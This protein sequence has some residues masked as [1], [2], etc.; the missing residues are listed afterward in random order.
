MVG[1]AV[2]AALVVVVP[3]NCPIVDVAGATAVVA[4]VAVVPLD[5]ELGAVAVVG[6]VVTGV[7]VP[8]GAVGAGGAPL[9][10]SGV[11]VLVGPALGVPPLAATGGV[12][13]LVGS[14]VPLPVVIGPAGDVLGAAV[15]GLVVSGL[16]PPPV[17]PAEPGGAEA[18]PL[19]DP[20]LAV[21]GLVKLLVGLVVS[22]LEPVPTALDGAEA[23]PLG[24]PELAVVGVRPPVAGSSV[25][26]V[27]LAAVGPVMAPEPAAPEPAEPAA[28]VPEP[29]VPEPVLPVV[30]DEFTGAAALGGGEVA[31][32]SPATVLGLAAGPLAA[33]LGLAAMLGVAAG[34]LAVVLGLAPPSDIWI[35]GIGQ[36]ENVPKPIAVT[37]LAP[38]TLYVIW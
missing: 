21:V 4:T 6:E 34:P 10:L 12:T 27:R 28:P 8:V 19:G 11:L 31:T 5:A 29:E 30:R 15:L 3:G 23:D 16:E 25:V 1:A 35:T 9:P 18:D 7:V 37:P 26:G 2:S 24:D 13:W 32:G 14:A 22:W 20:E 38:S 33:G 17:E 36:V